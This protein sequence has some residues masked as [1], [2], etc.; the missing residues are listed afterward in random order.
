MI[1]KWYVNNYSTTW[2][3]PILNTFYGWN[4]VQINM[5]C[6]P[7]TIISAADIITNRKVGTASTQNTYNTPF[8]RTAASASDVMRR[9][10]TMERSN[11]RSSGNALG[12]QVTYV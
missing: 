5:D 3:K 7:D 2:K 10:E 4:S 9:T 12:G 8:P 11:A 6:Y 1:L